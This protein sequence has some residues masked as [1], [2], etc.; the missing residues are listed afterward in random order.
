VYRAAGCKAGCA[1]W[2]YYDEVH[3]QSMR[4]LYKQ[5]GDG[6]HVLC[7]DMQENMKSTAYKH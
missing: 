5:Q 4:L 3:I 6:E 2:Y 7:G 1:I